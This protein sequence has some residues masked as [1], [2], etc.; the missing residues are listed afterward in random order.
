M[1]LW[2]AVCLIPADNALN[3][4]PLLVACFIGGLTSR[5][6][7]WQFNKVPLEQAAVPLVQTANWVCLGL[8]TQQ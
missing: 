8:T 3:R 1:V 7:H 5:Q 6:F 4:N 2:L